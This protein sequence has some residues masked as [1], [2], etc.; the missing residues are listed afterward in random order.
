MSNHHLRNKNLSLKAKGLLCLM[1][2]LPDEW[3]YSTKGL[4]YICKEGVDSIANTVK[5]LELNGY[6]VRKRI[7]NKRGYLTTIEYTIYEYPQADLPIVEKPKPENPVLD[8]PV[9][10]NTV[11]LNTNISNKDKLN[12]DALNTYPILSNQ[13]G[14]LDRI[15]NED[16]YD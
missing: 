8:N 1:L 4:A 14:F 11:Q 9:L 6:I 10:D 5:E 2:S 12:I 13:M 16:K 15:G 3:D 7:R